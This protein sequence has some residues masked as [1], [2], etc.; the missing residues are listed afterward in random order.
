[1]SALWPAWYSPLRAA[2][3]RDIVNFAAL[4]SGL[5]AQDIRG[6][7]R[8]ATFVR[9]RWAV[10]LVAREN[11]HA[12]THIGR[13]IGNRDHTTIINGV[14][15]A[16]RYAAADP[17]FAQFV[18]EL[19]ALVLTRRPVMT[20]ADDRPVIVKAQRKAKAP[21]IATNDDDAPEEVDDIELLSRAVAA[22]YA[23]ASA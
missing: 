6:P 4:L 11:G 22:H 1:M 20:A 16:P 10:Y 19:R 3:V 8:L 7:S 15:K 12:Y 5:R 23:G 21:P 18:S 14:E 13:C 2:P 17:L 9:V